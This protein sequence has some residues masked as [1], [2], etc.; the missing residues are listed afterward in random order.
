[1][2]PPDEK[3][4]RGGYVAGKIDDR[5]RG[6]HHESRETA[7]VIAERAGLPDEMTPTRLTWFD[8]GPWKAL[9]VHACPALHQWPTPHVDVVEGV[10]DQ[11][12]PPDLDELV[13][14]HGGLS[15]HRTRG[16]MSV[17]CASEA[18]NM[19]ALNLAQDLMEGRMTLHKARVSFAQRFANAGT[20]LTDP[21]L[22]RLLFG[23]QVRTADPDDPHGGRVHLR[24]LSREPSPPDRRGRI[25]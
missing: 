22:S 7:L 20:D 6:W 12:A 5:M 21:Y 19:C 15:Y 23:R 17:C 14:F 8:V 4:R 2:S 9:V 13:A 18:T 11:H 24:A 3:P 1:M 16:E 25:D 10:I